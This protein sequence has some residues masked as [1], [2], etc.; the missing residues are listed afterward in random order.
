[1]Q[2]VRADLVA[3]I[4]RLRRF[5]YAI[6]GSR[7]DGDDLVQAACVRAIDRIDQFQAGTRLDSWMFRIIHNLWI[8]FGR[9]RRRRGFETDPEALEHLSDGGLAAR[10]AEDRLMLAQ[11]RQAVADL[12]EDQRAVLVL[13]CIEGHSYKEAAA[14]LDI[15]VGTV[16]SR[17]ARARQRLQYVLG[18]VQ[19]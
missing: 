1:M 5:A 16:M 19:S 2:D 11:V 8:D 7:V 3:L 9:A 15:P 18:E 6:S 13:V 4:P 17:L 10:R 12:P 14:A